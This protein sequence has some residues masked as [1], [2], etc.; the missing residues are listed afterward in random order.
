VILV[1]GSKLGSLD[2]AS[3]LESSLEIGVGVVGMVVA[4]VLGLDFQNISRSLKVDFAFSFSSRCCNCDFLTVLFIQLQNFWLLTNLL[5]EIGGEQSFLSVTFLDSHQ[6][7][8]FLLERV[9]I[10]NHLN[11]LAGF[12][13]K[14]ILVLS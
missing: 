1:L 11:N 14:F 12:K 13:A 5:G 4:R 8:F 10:L 7:A 9:F 6:P 2:A 3:L